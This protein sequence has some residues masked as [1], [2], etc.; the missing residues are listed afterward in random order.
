MK[1]S[2][3]NSWIGTGTSMDS[4]Q[5]PSSNNQRRF[6]T[7]ELTIGVN[8]GELNAPSPDAT[9]QPAPVNRTTQLPSTKTLELMRQLEALAHEVALVSRDQSS[10]RYIKVQEG[11]NFS[12]GLQL[13]KPSIGVS[14]RDQL[15]SDSS[16][17]GR[18]TN[19]TLA[20]FFTFA[21]DQLGRHMPSFGRPSATLTGFFTAARDWL[22]S[23]GPSL[24]RQTPATLTGFFIAARD[25]LASF[26]PSL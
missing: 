4:F 1:K 11:S 14:P 15:A 8:P 16:L 5:S 9:L 18:R 3:F 26:R 24:G 17:F 23:F 20:G 2:P 10:N 7:T 13:V 12:A 25:W 19:L 22:A 6:W 21:L